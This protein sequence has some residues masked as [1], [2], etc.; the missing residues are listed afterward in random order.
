MKRL[1]RTAK[2]VDTTLLTRKAI[3]DLLERAFAEHASRADLED[4]GDRLYRLGD[5]IVPALVRK[6]E[7]TDDDGALARL[8]F[9]VEYLDHEAFVEPL[10]DLLLSRRKSDRAKAA[11]LAALQA[12]NV[13]TSDPLFDDIFDRPGVALA[14]SASRLVDEAEAAEES[15]VRFLESFFGYSRAHKLTIV[16]ELGKLEDRRAVRYLELLGEHEDAEIA[17]LAVDTLGRVRDGRAVAALARLA[18]R[19]AEP[20]RRARAE[21]SLRR[22]AFAGLPVAEMRRRAMLPSRLGALYKVHVSRFDSQGGRALWFAR[23]RREDGPSLT[24][25]CLLIDDEYG[26]KDGFGYDEIERADYESLL[27][28]ARK[29][30]SLVET[31]FRYAVTLLRDALARNQAGDN[32][33][34]P[35]FLLLRRFFEATDL[36]PARYEPVFPELDETTLLD[37]LACLAETGSLL[38]RD[39]FEGWLVATERVYDYADEVRGLADEGTR[40][41]FVRRSLDISQRFFEELVRP[42]LP[43]YRGRLRA[44]ADLLR[45]AGNRRRD[46][47]LALVAAAHIDAAIE[48]RARVP[49]TDQPFVHRLIFESLDL[50]VTALNDGYDLRKESDDSE[51]E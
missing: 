8:A 13:D 35:H 44:A 51:A 9:L 36:T 47:R 29:E 6:L 12:Y 46:V 3:N 7:E 5:A 45:R 31:D 30:E 40:R 41:R 32:P 43:R 10:V 23:R 34:P 25:V 49:I 27:R 20:V 38:D 15:P 4:I 37:D 17:M 1:R 11:L 28:K 14:H 22:L 33:Y 16:A 50:A 24:A 39:E 21:R 19:Q 26:L 18:A 42:E 2:N 48:R